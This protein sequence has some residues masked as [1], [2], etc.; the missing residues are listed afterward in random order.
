MRYINI[1]CCINGVISGITIY[2]LSLVCAALPYLNIPSISFYLLFA[3]CILGGAVIIGALLF[4]K[5]ATVGGALIRSLLMF[6]SSICMLMV[7]GHLGT[8][9]F[10]HELLVIR[11]SS[12]ADNA[13]GMLALTYFTI[14]I[15]ICIVFI[16]II[17][18][19]SLCCKKRIR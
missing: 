3:I 19:L 16:L 5:K 18:I 6:L 15:V 14:M 4:H 11:P 13:S 17:L 2:F 7:N 10:V 8:V 12:S 9:R 1:H